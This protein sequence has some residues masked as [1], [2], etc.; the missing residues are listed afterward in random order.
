[1]QFRGFLDDLFNANDNAV[2]LRENIERNDVYADAHVTW[3]RRRRVQWIVGGDLLFGNG[4]GRGATFNYTVP[5]SGSPAIVVPIPTSLNLDAE[6]RRTFTG[7]YLLAEIAPT[8]A[9]RI[10]SGLRMN[11]TMERR[12]EGQSVTHARPSGSVGAIV[13]VWQR[14]TNQLKV[15][16]DYRD[17]FKPAA[18][19]FSLAENEGVLDPETARSIEAGVKTLS[20]GGRVAIDASV[21]RMNFTNLVTSR[22]IDGLPALINAGET[23]FQGFELTGEARGPHHLSG[24]ATYS[25]HDGRFI[26]FVQVFDGVPT[27]LGGKRFEMTSRHTF[28]SG[29]V[30]AP[31]HGVVSSVIVKYAGDRYLNKRN[32]ALAAPF[33]TVDAGIGYRFGSFE[34]RL[35]GRNLGDRRDPIAESELGDS[36]YYRLFSRSVRV[37]AGARF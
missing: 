20:M 35:D 14:R 16:A 25:Y 27:Q 9:V 31:E 30:L 29:L 6:S 4:E 22:V 8:P 13:N 32:T 26:D 23:R 37:S 2:G 3:P 15:F 11:V 5:L 12:G 33:T 24:R 36:Q 34:I 21:F 10:S 7:G 1:M 19:D 28:S 17:T 18:F